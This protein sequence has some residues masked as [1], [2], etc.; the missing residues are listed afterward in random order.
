MPELTAKQTRWIEEFLVDG[1]ATG[2]AR[3]AGYSEKSAKQI[4]TENLSKPHIK[5]ALATAQAKLAQAVGLT[6]EMVTDGSGHI[7]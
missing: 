3:R 7:S 4:G 5:D 6:A 2:A 1:N